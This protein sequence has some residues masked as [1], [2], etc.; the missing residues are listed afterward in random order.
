MPDF[1]C[2]LKPA[3][4]IESF[5]FLNR[6]SCSLPSLLGACPCLSFPPDA[7]HRIQVVSL[8]DSLSFSRIFAV[9]LSSAPAVPFKAPDRLNQSSSF[10][11][12][13]VIEFFC[14]GA[15]DNL[16][17]RPP[18]APISSYQQKVQV[19]LMFFP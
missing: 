9:A 14:H 13:N 19:Q 1:E 6:R 10:A 11:I 3:P 12:L 5:S 4:A 8:P 2:Q 18:G 16:L 17:D 7:A 15:P